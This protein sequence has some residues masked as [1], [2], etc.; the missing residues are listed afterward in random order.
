MAVKDLL[1]ELQRLVVYVN[2]INSK[3]C[4]YL[5]VR[6]VFDNYAKEN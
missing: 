6:V 5:Q 2:I 1:K 4:G 3:A